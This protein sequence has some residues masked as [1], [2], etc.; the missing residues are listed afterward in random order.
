MKIHNY[1][2]IILLVV[3]SNQFTNAQVA[4]DSKI[5]KI[6]DTRLF[7]DSNDRNAF[8]YLPS[9]PRVVKKDSIY[10]FHLWKY[11]GI[12]NKIYGGIFSAQIEFALSVEERQE[13]SKLLKQKY[14]K[15]YLKEQ[16]PLF[17]FQNDQKHGTVSFKVVT[18]T[19]NTK[20]QILT[21]GYAPVQ[22]GSKA[23]IMLELNRGQ[24]S[25]LEQLFKMGTSDLSIIIK[26]YYPEKSPKFDARIAIPSLN[27]N[28]V[29]KGKL[30]SQKDIED[31]S[32]ALADKNNI[33]VKIYDSDESGDK[34]NK[35]IKLVTAKLLSDMFTP[36]EKCPNNS[37]AKSKC[38]KLKKHHY[39]VKDSLFVSV[40]QMGVRRVPVIA[41]GNINIFSDTLVK[42]ND[43]VSVIKLED[44]LG[45]QRELDFGIN[46]TYLDAFKNYI[47]AVS[48]KIKSDSI[49]SKELSFTWQDVKNGKYRKKIQIPFKNNGKYEYR[50]SW[51]L[52]KVDTIISSKWLTSQK[53]FIS[54]TPPLKKREITISFDGTGKQ[55]V[56]RVLVDFKAFLGRNKKATT[57]ENLMIKN[58]GKHYLQSVTV[59]TDPDSKLYS[60]TYKIISGK[61]TGDKQFKTVSDNNILN[62]N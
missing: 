2:A 21:S 16:L 18:N 37:T 55:K 9:S 44:E 32:R 33:D 45:K 10:K 58:T 7:Q 28:N 14:P 20:E 15:A 50:I 17:T 8:Y 62:I 59:F 31:I 56:K 29:A 60:R 1:I 48:V 23:S 6:N 22:F 39:D 26:A 47:N 3:L 43:Y 19:I 51:N 25:L 5:I 52:A 38:F 49:Y 35:V 4:F 24:T 40:Q 41:S 34:A 30:L 46:E 11:M 42:I 53:P 54:L 27:V 12:E 13:L 61:G 36:N 57:V